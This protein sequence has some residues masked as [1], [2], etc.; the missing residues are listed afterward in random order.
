MRLKILY[1]IWIEFFRDV[2][3]TVNCIQ[4]EASVMQTSRKLSKTVEFV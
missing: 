3:I 4:S 1:K 2:F